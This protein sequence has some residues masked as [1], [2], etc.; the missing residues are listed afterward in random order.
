MKNLKRARESRGMTKSGL[1]RQVNLT[2]LAIH[3]YENGKIKNPAFWHVHNIAK[4]L[5]IP[6]IDLMGEPDP[7]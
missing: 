3:R 4:I 7:D 1:A 2:Y 5:D 6:M